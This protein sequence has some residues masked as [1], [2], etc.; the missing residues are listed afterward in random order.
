MEQE[1]PQDQA[2]GLTARIRRARPPRNSVD[3]RRPVHYLV[4]VEC[5]AAGNVEDVATVFL[6]N[7]ECPFTC[8]MC[9]LWRNT[10]VDSVPPGAIPEQIAFALQRM[11][12]ARHIK[13]YNSGNFFDPRA[14]PP[15]DWPAIADRLRGFDSVIVENHP[16]LCDQ[17]CVEFQALLTDRAAGDRSATSRPADEP[18]PMKSATAAAAPQLE[19]AVGLETSHAPTLRR[20]N[21]QMTTSDFAAACEFLLRHRIRIRTFVLLRPPGVSEEQG[22]RQAIDSIRFA[23]DCGVQC[24]AVIPTRPGNGILDEMLRAG[25]WSPPTLRSL[26]RVV[27]EAVSWNQARIF[28]DLW[29]IESFVDCRVCGPARIRRL[30]EM[31]LRQR[32]LPGPECSA[33]D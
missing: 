28:A 10:T 16:R 9:D 31:N 21:K 6:T 5:S 8:L 18:P 27:D 30:R 4:E 13:L 14:I 17:R 1:Q 15:S 11:P 2:S 33:C 24:V 20:L 32:V 23:I 25:T 12:S 3:P 19:V 7:R 29:D 22:V 26:E